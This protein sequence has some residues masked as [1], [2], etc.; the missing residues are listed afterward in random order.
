VFDCANTIHPKQKPEASNMNGMHRNNAIDPGL[1]RAKAYEIWQSLGCPEGAAEQTWFEAER[2][3]SRQPKPA[4]Q[5]VSS[6]PRVVDEEQPA[7]AAARVSEPPPASHSKSI[8]EPPA[9]AASELKPKKS[10]ASPRRTTR[11]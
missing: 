7:I 1:V 8:S 4:E 6:R 5:D 9:T 3:L 10:A 2:Q 11:R